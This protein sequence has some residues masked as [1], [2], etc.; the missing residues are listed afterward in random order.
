MMFNECH[1][2]D[3]VRALTVPVPAMAVTEAMITASTL[4]QH[5]NLM[6]LTD[7]EVGILIQF[8]S[9]NINETLESDNV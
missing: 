9:D 1:V 3:F 5:Q 2:S 8:L 6:Y 4:L 7:A